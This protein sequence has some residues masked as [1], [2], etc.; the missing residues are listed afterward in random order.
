MATDR[1]IRPQMS[2]I[3]RQL[4]AAALIGQKVPA[5]VIG[6]GITFI[7]HCSLE[8]SP[9]GG[10]EENQTGN[11]VDRAIDR[12]AEWAGIDSSLGLECWATE[13]LPDLSIQMS[14]GGFHPLI[15]TDAFIGWETMPK[16]T[17]EQQAEMP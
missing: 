13:A 10:E 11:F 7:L 2:K 4:A 15:A 9:H 12:V 1:Q 16:G 17:T 3:A 5:E 8:R 6:G 14:L